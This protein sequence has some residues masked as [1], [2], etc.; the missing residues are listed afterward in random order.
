MSSIQNDETNNG[1]SLLNEKEILSEEAGVNK[2]NNENLI[3]QYQLRSE[4]DRINE[5]IKICE[6]YKKN[7]EKEIKDFK[8]SILQKKYIEDKIAFLK[9]EQVDL[10]KEQSLLN[11]ENKALKLES[12]RLLKYKDQIKSDIDMILQKFQEAKHVLDFN[13]SS[14]ET[15][16]SELAILEKNKCTLLEEISVLKEEKMKINSDIEQLNLDGNSLKDKFASELDKLK[17]E[18][19]LTNNNNNPPEIEGLLQDNSSPDQL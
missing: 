14:T 8:K 16:K 17:S 7:L 1:V 19:G 13:D 4:L 9:L 10:Q 6:L 11:I 3:E 18:L 12:E 5:D 2:A 15:L